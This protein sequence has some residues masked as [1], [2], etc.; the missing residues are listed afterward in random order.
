[1]L[2]IEIDSARHE[3]EQSERGSLRELLAPGIRGAFIAGLGLAVLQQ[4]VGP[5]TVLFYGPTI[6]GNAGISAG[7][8]GLLAEIC[9]G[10]V[11]LSSCYRRSCSSTLSDVSDCPT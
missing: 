10:V 11:C 6:F 1:V 4:F 7:S 2:N 8:G 3:L 5:N 9:V